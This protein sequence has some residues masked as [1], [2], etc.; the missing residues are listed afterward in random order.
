M[1]IDIY[2]DTIAKLDSFWNFSPFRV[3]GKVVPNPP[4]EIVE[5][6]EFEDLPTFLCKGLSVGCK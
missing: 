2:V 1:L 3:V 5:I 4:H 6:P